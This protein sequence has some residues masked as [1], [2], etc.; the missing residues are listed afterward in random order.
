[1]CEES[2]WCGP[3]MEEGETASWAAGAVTVPTFSDEDGR[4]YS[5]FSLP[6]G[7]DSPAEVKGL[8]KIFMD[9]WAY[10]RGQARE[11]SPSPFALLTSASSSLIE[12]NI[13]QI[14]LK[15]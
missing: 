2:V 13:I 15:K 4:E 14:K 8:P 10:P 6:Q 11:C 7:P 3:G 12:K 1:M 9:M 5:H